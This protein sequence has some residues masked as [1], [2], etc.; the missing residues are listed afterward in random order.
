[1]F[2]DYE[3]STAQSRLREQLASV[4][5]AYVPSRED[6]L[7][8]E[9][10]FDWI[11]TLIQKIMEFFS[12]LFGGA[13]GSV[14]ST[15]AKIAEVSQVWTKATEEQKKT[16]VA[17]FKITN[18]TNLVG[19]GPSLDEYQKKVESYADAAAVKK[20][21]SE[22]G[23]QNN[24]GSVLI[25]GQE[26][27]KKIDEAVAEDL[28]SL[29][30]GTLENI[31]AKAAA[32]E[33]ALQDAGKVRANIEN[34]LQKLK[35]EDNENKAKMRAKHAKKVTEVVGKYVMAINRELTVTQNDAEKLGTKLKG[36]IQGQPAQQQP[37]PAN[38][39]AIA[40]SQPQKALP[41]PAQVSQFTGLVT[42]RR[43]SGYIL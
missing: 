26:L 14:G 41:A 37:A 31:Q 42:P 33:K 40:T 22:D 29:I 28:K 25:R 16:A 20:E 3:E 5:N 6:P 17:D 34:S 9:G 24:L 36:V 12:G 1:M 7:M 19:V 8:L 2:L 32:L 21:S 38:N 13:G 43:I 4:T 18:Y 10:F 39:A 35:L 23:E 11:A 15:K 27:E 30:D